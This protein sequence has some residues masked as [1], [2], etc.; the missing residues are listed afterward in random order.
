MINLKING[1][2]EASAGRTANKD[3]KS[4]WDWWLLWTADEFAH[5]YTMFTIIVH[6]IMI[7][8]NNNTDYLEY[9]MNKHK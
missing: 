4:L 5:W 8:I 1:F 9:E 3:N 2:S 6:N 7:I